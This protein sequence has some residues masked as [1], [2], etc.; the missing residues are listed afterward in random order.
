MAVLTT[1][2]G[3]TFSGA[4]VNQALAASRDLPG[5]LTAAKFKASGLIVHLQ[6]MQNALPAGDSQITAIASIITSIS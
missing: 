3:I 1:L 6:Q 5:L 2:N 4:D